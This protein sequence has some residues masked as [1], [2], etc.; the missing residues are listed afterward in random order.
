MSETQD[1]TGT[2]G[3]FT[4]QHADGEMTFVHGVSIEKL[5]KTGS[6]DQLQIAERYIAATSVLGIPLATFQ[7]LPEAERIA[8]IKDH[9]KQQSQVFGMPQESFDALPEQERVELIRFHL[10]QEVE[11]FG[12]PQ[13]TFEK[14]DS[15]AQAKLAALYFEAEKED[16]LTTREGEATRR[17]EIAAE[18]EQ[19]AHENALAIEHERTQRWLGLSFAAAAALTIGALVWQDAVD[20]NSVIDKV[21]AALQHHGEPAPAPGQ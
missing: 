8:I 3:M 17:E 11:I 16:H 14:M 7:E 2:A 21:V 6:W 10:K 20:D 13:E 15:D 19:A 9:F 4:A 12:V 5:L 1:Q 18:R